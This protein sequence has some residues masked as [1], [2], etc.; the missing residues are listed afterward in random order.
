MLQRILLNCIKLI[1]FFSYCINSEHNGTYI[2]MHKRT[3]TYIMLRNSYRP[4]TTYIL[5]TYILYIIYILQHFAPSA[6]GR[7]SGVADF[8][9][10]VVK[11]IIYI[12][13]Y[14]HNHTRNH[15]QVAINQWLLDLDYFKI[16]E[17]LDY[18]IMIILKL[19]KTLDYSYSSIKLL[20]YDY[21]RIDKNN[22]LL[23][24]YDYFVI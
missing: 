23:V 6:W 11:I 4:Y 18:L 1:Y 5:Y 24:Y 3:V 19:I 16:I 22:R 13:I 20:D 7:A 17:I 9:N 21:L 15:R 12:A 14:N 2:Y 10:Q 8:C